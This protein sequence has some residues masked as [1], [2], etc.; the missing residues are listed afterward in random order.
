MAAATYVGGE[1]LPKK[2]GK[3]TDSYYEEKDPAKLP[4]LSTSDAA[5][6]YWYSGKKYY[7]FKKGQY[8]GTLQ[9]IHAKALGKRTAAETK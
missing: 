1:T 5:T 2:S 8:K 7:D 3:C 9:T 6:E 4:T